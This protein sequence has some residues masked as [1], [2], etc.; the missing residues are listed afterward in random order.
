MTLGER[1]RK[2]RTNKAFSLEELAK[3]TGLT[4]SFLSQV[5]KNR[6]SPSINS[7]IKIAEA[8]EVRIGDLF[9]ENKNG[10][11][12]YIIHANERESYTLPKNKIRIELLAPRK[13]AL[14]FEPMLIYLGV[15]A[16]SG[17]IIAPRPFFCFILEGKLELT[18]GEE[19]HVLTKGDSI[20]LDTPRE[21]SWKNIGESEVVSF[22]VGIPPL[23]N[24]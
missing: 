21:H 14:G 3:K 13:N 4:R 12:K 17:K 11:D 6:T 20:Y 2:I 19:T 15:G 1:L 7:L 23:R 5:E 8:L 18:I 22:G 16:A 9:L 10:E 24:S